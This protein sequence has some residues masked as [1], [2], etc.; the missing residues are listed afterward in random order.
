MR[1]LFATLF[2]VFGLF[3]TFCAGFWVD[4]SEALRAV[5]LGEGET[6]Q[7]FGRYRT[8]TVFHECS[9][10]H[11]AFD[12]AVSGQ[13]SSRTETVC[14]QWPT[15]CIPQKQLKLIPAAGL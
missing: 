13:H 4:D 9:G 6:A 3:H 1:I 15:G 11:A 10:F 8:L 5:K 2:A 7:V 14:C 12:V